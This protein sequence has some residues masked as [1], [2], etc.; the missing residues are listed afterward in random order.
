MDLIQMALS[1]RNKMD[2]H[3]R[4]DN[5]KRLIFE[6]RPLRFALSE[7]NWKVLRSGKRDS[8]WI[9]IAA[10]YRMGF[11]D[12]GGD[13]SVPASVVQNV[14]TQTRKQPRD[15]AMPAKLVPNRLGMPAEINRHRCERPDDGW[16]CSSGHCP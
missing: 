2:D 11:G 12:Q 13:V 1:I 4:Y 10:D 9:Y 8:I 15:G 3:S 14:A 6:W 5:V 7:L 16:Q